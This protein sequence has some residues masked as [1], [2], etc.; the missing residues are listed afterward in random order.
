LSFER[1]RYLLG[2]QPRFC[3]RYGY[4]FAQALSTPQSGLDSISLSSF[5]H[6]ET[7]HEAHK[8]FLDH[9]NPILLLED[10][11]LSAIDNSVK[12]KQV[13]VSPLRVEDADG[14]LCTVFANIVK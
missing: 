6:R 8:A 2:K 11:D 12:L 7:G 14:T 10:M 1:E 3:P 4:F 13:I 9:P 5:T